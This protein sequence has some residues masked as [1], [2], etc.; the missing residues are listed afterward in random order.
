MRGD[1]WNLGVGVEITSSICSSL[2][3]PLKSEENYIYYR[4]Q[5]KIVAWKYGMLH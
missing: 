2:V 4:S 3:L 5:G 1:I